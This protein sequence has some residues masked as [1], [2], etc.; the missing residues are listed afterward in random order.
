MAYTVN[1]K[2]KK[3]LE[4]MQECLDD[5]IPRLKNLDKYELRMLIVTLAQYLQCKYSESG[6]HNCGDRICAD[7]GALIKIFNGDKDI[8]RVAQSIID[9]WYLINLMPW[10]PKTTRLVLEMQSDEGLVRLL[11]KEGLL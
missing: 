8:I 2:P 11:N 6:I 5:C 4:D 3:C 9:L 10:N 7:D 1:Y